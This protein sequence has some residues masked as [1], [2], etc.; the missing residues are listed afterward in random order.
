MNGNTWEE[1]VLCYSCS[2]N[3]KLLRWT[4]A[5]KYKEEKNSG[6]K[7]GLNQAWIARGHSKPQILRYSMSLLFVVGKR[8]EAGCYSF[9]CVL[10][11]C[12]RGAAIQVM[13]DKKQ[14]YSGDQSSLRSHLNAHG[15]MITKIMSV[16]LLRA[17]MTYFVSFVLLYWMYILF[18]RRTITSSLIAE[19]QK[20]NTWCATREK[21]PQPS[22]ETYP[23]VLNYQTKSL[24]TLEICLI[25]SY[26][27]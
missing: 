16:E 6:I 19:M 23:L 8:G 13:S 1:N 25:C 12:A 26:T 4:R 9:V 24:S 27:L 10:C 17:N 15:W 18:R 5:S 11:V 7:M 22:T 20:E 14:S 2:R 3:V 21:T